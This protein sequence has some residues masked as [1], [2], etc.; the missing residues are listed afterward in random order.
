MA[1]SFTVNGSNTTITFAYTKDTTTIQSIIGNAA[2]YLWNHGYGDHGTEAAPILFSSLT[3]NQKLALVEDHIK[4]VVVDA[5]NTFK[6]VKAQDEAKAAEE[7]NKFV[8]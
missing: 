4:D 8:L 1:S 5:A 3:N 2:E 6:S 7:A